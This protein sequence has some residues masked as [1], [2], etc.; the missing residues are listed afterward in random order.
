MSRKAPAADPHAGWWD[1]DLERVVTGQLLLNDLTAPG[2]YDAYVGAGLRPEHFHQTMCQ[3]IWQAA[4]ILA[5]AEQPVM[6]TAIHRELHRMGRS[7]DAPFNW[8]TRLVDGVPWPRDLNDQRAYVRANAERLHE[9]WALRQTAIGTKAVATELQGAAPDAAELQAQL[10]EMSERLS[11]PLFT[12]DG[13]PE[14]VLACALTSGG[15]PGSGA[16]L[17]LETIDETFY[18]IKP[19]QVCLI[20]ARSSVGKTQV[21]CRS[22]FHTQ[23]DAGWGVLFFSM[24]QPTSEIFERF[25]RIA[26]GLNR[27]EYAFTKQEQTIDQDLWLH[28]YPRLRIYDGP[29]S[30]AEIDQRI[31]RA[32]HDAFR[33]LPGIAVIIDY[34]TLIRGDERLTS[35]ERL[36]KFARE[37]KQLVKRRRVAFII[38]VQVGREAG[39]D[40][41]LL[42]P[43]GAAR[44]SGQ[45]E[46]CADLIVGLRRLDTPRATD[47]I[48]SK[49]KAVLFAH[50]MKHKNGE[51]LAREI[52][53]RIDWR[54]YQI[55][56]DSNLQPPESASPS[57]GSMGRRRR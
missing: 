10:T 29:R 34:F 9:L 13:M 46:E 6:L 33:D 35:Y 28:T 44:D 30:L 11:K 31:V 43:L 14:T 55:N 4:A 2:S 15:Q 32:Q 18:G 57:M 42:L 36:S 38:A 22:A 56:E 1:K 48:R 3:V 8:L 23:R 37:I 49:Y 45:I 20:E 52:A 26:T 40:G 39:G 17:G 21:L 51:P 41:D 53:Y 25:Y 24:E 16:L 50:I 7:A 5:G 19:G 54:G 47:E 27:H 12:D